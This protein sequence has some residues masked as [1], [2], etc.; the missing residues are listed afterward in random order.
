MSRYN[1]N[2]DNPCVEVPGNMAVAL[3]GTSLYPEKATAISSALSAVLLELEAALLVV[4]LLDLVTAGLSVN[5]HLEILH[6]DTL[7]AGATDVAA[8]P[9]GVA[10]L[11]LLAQGRVG[12]RVLLGAWAGSGFLGCHFDSLKM[13]LLKLQKCH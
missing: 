13:K 12:R 6:Q 5:D 1:R 8:G 9:L 7:T 2:S 10:L 4:R 3:T 11:L